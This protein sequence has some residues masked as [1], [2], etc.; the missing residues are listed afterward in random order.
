MRR[1]TTIGLLAVVAL[2]LGVFGAGLYV[3]VPGYTLDI[4]G[5]LG[6]VPIALGGAFDAVEAALADAGVPPSELAG[7]AEE[8]DRA[9]EDVEA[10]LASV[11]TLVPVPLIGGAV[12]FPL[13]LGPIN[14]L[15]ITGGVLTDGLIRG[16][17]EIADVDLPVPLFEGTVETDAGTLSIRVDPAVSTW[18]FSA[19]LVARLDLIVAGIS[20][21]AGADVIGGSVAPAIDLDVPPEWTDPAAAVIAALHTDGLTWSSFGVHA[22]FG[23]EFGLPFLRVYADARVRMPIGS[24][25]G[26]W[27]LRVASWSALVGLVIRF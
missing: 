7:I 9:L 13:A 12:E 18:M 5:T 2:T 11:P 10:N 27:D 6:Q 25:S 3:G 20:V 1:S 4:A 17:A 16:F 15:R 23:L 14:G 21:A 22:G 26:W 19:E 24:A 8:F